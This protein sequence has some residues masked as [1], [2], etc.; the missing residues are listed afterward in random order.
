MIDSQLL[1]HDTK[2]WGIPQ[3]AF[4]NDYNGWLKPYSR[5]VMHVY[6]LSGKQATGVSTMTRNWRMFSKCRLFGTEEVRR[7][8]I[9]SFIIS[10][11]KGSTSANSLD[12]L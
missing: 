9:K 1:R 10:R 11:F 6:L 4:H 5:K 3:M 7:P 2:S 12:S 8:P